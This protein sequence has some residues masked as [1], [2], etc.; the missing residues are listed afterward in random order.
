[1]E[2]L[3]SRSLRVVFFAVLIAWALFTV[4]PLYW[5]TVTSLKSPADTTAGKPTFIPGLD[6]EPTLQ[7]YR[8]IFGSGEGFEVQGM[9]DVGRLARNSLIAALSSGVLAILLG[10]SAAYALSRFRFYRWKNKDIA[11][12]IISQRMFPP[13]ALVVPYF[14]LFNKLEILDTIGSLILVYTAMNLPLVVWLLRDYFRD[15]PVELEEAAMVDG[16]TR[17]G[18]FFRIALPLTLPGL[19]VAFLFAFVFAWNEFLFAFTLSFDKAKTLPVQIAGGVTTTGVRYWDIAAQSLVV[20]IPPL[21][22]ALLTG[23]YIIRGLTLGAVKH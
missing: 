5:T 3:R 6:F 13:I 12:W 15:L 10:T 4:F 16:S 2:L 20:M 21:I 19:V 17:L 7:P 23:R 14:I 9:G 11:F 18:A 8:N 22:V 1:M